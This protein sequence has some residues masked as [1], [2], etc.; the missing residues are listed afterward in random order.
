LELYVA[1]GGKMHVE[2]FSQVV[3]RCDSSR[4]PLFELP[5]VRYHRNV[6][7]RVTSEPDQLAGFHEYNVRHPRGLIVVVQ[8]I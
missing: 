6:G 4:F 2:A 8:S 3:W 1:A 5:P 7:S